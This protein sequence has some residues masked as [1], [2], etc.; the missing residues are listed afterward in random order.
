MGFPVTYPVSIWT[1]FVQLLPNLDTVVFSP[2]RCVE[3][4]WFNLD[5]LWISR[6]LGPSGSRLG[7]SRDAPIGLGMMII[8]YG[9]MR[10]H[11]AIR[12]ST[13]YC[14]GRLV[15]D[16][17]YIAVV[18]SGSEGQCADAPLDAQAAS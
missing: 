8:I 7:L 11:G 4:D 16:G 5:P 15:K 3:A 9:Y 6:G 18:D 13:R 1:L 10:Q 17:Y 2:P 12:D 14:D